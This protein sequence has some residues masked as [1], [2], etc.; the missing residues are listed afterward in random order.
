MQQV[1]F[2]S[3]HY[4][5]S[6][7]S[8]S[9]VIRGNARDDYGDNNEPYSFDLV[10]VSYILLQIHSSHLFVLSTSLIVRCQV[11]LCLF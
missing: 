11:Y 8:Y 3:D 9:T 2:A 5:Y 10:V 4:D 1:G 6:E 7:D